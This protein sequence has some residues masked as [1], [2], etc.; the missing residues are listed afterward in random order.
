MC[1]CSAVVY[2]TPGTG[3][4]GFQSKGCSTCICLHENKK[5]NGFDCGK[6][7][8]NNVC[9]QQYVGMP[10][11]FSFCFRSRTRRERLGRP[12]PSIIKPTRY[13]VCKLLV[14]TCDTLYWMFNPFRTAVPFWGQTTQLSSSLSRQRDCGPKRDKEVPGTLYCCL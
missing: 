4:H 9:L 1:C 7:K 6:H 10:R 2:M 11:D 3:M 14:R 8:H 13:L 5:K 12:K